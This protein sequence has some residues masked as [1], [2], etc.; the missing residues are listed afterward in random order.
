[1]DWGRG[2]SHTTLGVAEG[3]KGG[4]TY[5][6][7]LGVPRRSR[8][9]SSSSI[10]SHINRREER[11]IYHQYTKQLCQGNMWRTQEKINIFQSR[12]YNNYIKIV[13]SNPY[14][15]TQILNK[16]FFNIKKL[17]IEVNPVKLDY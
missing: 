5:H 2:T 10:V 1:M 13:F 9:G 6:T 3:N 12:Q 14:L 8:G 7:T 17:Y 4:E 15:I 16:P 11:N